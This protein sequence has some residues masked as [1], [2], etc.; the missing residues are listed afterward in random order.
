MNALVTLDP[1]ARY[2]AM[3]D[4]LADI[5]A[6][7]RLELAYAYANRRAI[8]L[9]ID[10]GVLRWKNARFTFEGCID[11]DLDHP[12]WGWI[13]FTA[14]PTDVEPYGRRIFWS[15]FNQGV[16]EPWQ[17]PPPPPIYMLEHDHVL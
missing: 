15:L 5:L 7:E 17:G 6:P 1:Q 13:P 12:L 4:E 3:A 8:N 14:S 10:R 9:L 11:I 2:P 16:A